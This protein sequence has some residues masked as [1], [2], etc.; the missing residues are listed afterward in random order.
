[1]LIPGKQLAPFIAF[2]HGYIAAAEIIVD[3]FGRK[4]RQLFPQLS[5]DIGLTIL[6]PD[7][8]K[9]ALQ[10][11]YRVFNSDVAC[12]IPLQPLYPRTDDAV[13]EHAVEY[14]VKLIGGESIPKS[15]PVEVTLITKENA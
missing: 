6:T 15:V 10:S 12:Q 8:E 9:V 3:P 5:Y 14:A 2:R 7:S 13:P 11:V 4:R 1:M